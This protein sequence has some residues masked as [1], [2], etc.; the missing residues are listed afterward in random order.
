[1]VVRQF[2]DLTFNPD[3]GQLSTTAG[4]SVQLR[5]KA[6]RLLSCLLDH[7][8]E[9]VTREQLVEAVWD[10]STVVDFESGL[11]A[12]LRELRQA[13]R[14]LGAPVE[15]VETLPR[16]GYRL[17]AVVERPDGATST[18]RP[19]RKRWPLVLTAIVLL[20]AAAGYALWRQPVVTAP[21]HAQCSV[22]I[23]PFRVYQSPPGLAGGAD[24]LLA[25][26]LLG[27]LLREPLGGMSLVGRTSLQPYLERSDVAAAVAED[28]GV[29]WLI[30]GAVQP[31]GA[32]QWRI[33]A[34]LLELP[35]GRVLWSE[36]VIIDPE[37]EGHDLDAVMKP[38]TDSLADAWPRLCSTH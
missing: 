23:M 33:E 13:T 29:D 16:R 30:E 15:L 18:R 1:M 3:D 14:S 12:L 21:E 31:T 28:L 37:Q 24:L 10:E 7:A 5:P 26:R 17:N 32:G 11:A 38:L 2:A 35:A 9:L 19:R 25:D 36:S 6:A 8:G 27:M 4:N 20:A 34:R 22:A